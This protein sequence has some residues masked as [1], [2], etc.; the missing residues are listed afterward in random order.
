MIAVMLGRVSIGIRISALVALA[1]CGAAAFAGIFANA[2]SRID[3]AVTAQ[4]GYQRLND[5]AA[6]TQIRSLTLQVLTEQFLRERN[7]AFAEAF[8]VEAGQLVNAL[9]TMQAI[10]QAE[11][12]ADRIAGLTGSVRQLAEQFRHLEVEVTR[13]GLTEEDGLRGK[14]RAS[15]KAIED[16]LRMWPNSGPVMVDMLNMRQAEKDFMIYGADSAL[17]YHR[18]YANQFDFQ[19]DATTLT[20]SVRSDFRRLLK[21]YTGDMAAFGSGATALQAEVERSRQHHFALRPEI[22]ALFGFARDGTERAVL[23]QEAVRDQ[24]LLEISAI[25][26]F[27]IF[28]FALAGMVIAQSI[29]KPIRQIETAMDRL[30]AGDHTVDIPGRDRRD[31]I[32]DMAKSLEVFKRNAEAVVNMQ[33]ERETIRLDAESASRARVMSLAE[34]FETAV[35]SVAGEVS[36]KAVIIHRA[37]GGMAGE[38]DGGRNAWALTVADAS[39]QARRTV[40]AVG[41]ATEKLSASVSEI[42]NHGAAVGRIVGSA[43]DELDMAES[44]VRALTEM[45]RRIDHVVALIG[46]IAQRTN[47]LSLNAAIEAQRAGPAGK[48]FAVVAGEVKRLAAQTQASTTEIAGQIAAIQAATADTVHAIGGVGTAI[49]EMDTIAQAVQNSVSH[50]KAVTREIETC[51][52][53]V[54][55]KTNMLT[56]GVTSFTHSAAQQCGAAARVLWA[57]EDLAA[58]TRIL[59]DEVNSFLVTVRAA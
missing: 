8:H 17:G 45:A 6:E 28:S 18:K 21:Q 9:Q 2:N 12:Q 33:T 19:L 30:A 51:V 49:R 40:V 39:D 26:I 15:V 58:P 11:E 25:G 16:E 29:V 20:D 4:D 34:R 35:Q 55:A 52:A 43:V 27:A 46:D 7:P 23:E 31:E 1:L 32:G 24:S 50:Q 22:E 47:M 48:G 54:T 3:E 37:A 13:L 59:K 10:P 56:E 5:L 42:A 38:E 57:A 14:L 36:D 44:R 53:D 41:V